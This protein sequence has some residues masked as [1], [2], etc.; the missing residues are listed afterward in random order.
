[1]EHRTGIKITGAQLDAVK[2]I[3]REDWAH[4]AQFAKLYGLENQAA[5]T[6]NT[7]KTLPG[8]A[9]MSA[10]P[11]RRAKGEAALKAGHAAAEKRT[12][13]VR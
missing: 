1:M 13:R 2:S 7:P 9:S 6:A 10:V 5:V 3:L 11:E 8:Q 4:G 12:R